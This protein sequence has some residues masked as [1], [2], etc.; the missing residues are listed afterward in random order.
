V[1]TALDGPTIRASESD[2]GVAPRSLLR[3][4]RGGVSS[5]ERWASLRAAMLTKTM[6]PSRPRGVRDEREQRTV[7]AGAIARMM[8][9]YVVS[10]LLVASALLVMWRYWRREFATISFRDAR[11]LREFASTPINALKPGLVKLVGVTK[12]EQGVMSY[13][14]R[15]PCVIHRRVVTTVS[16]YKQVGKTTYAETF[17]TREWT[18]IPFQLDDGT[19]TI[20]VDPRVAGTRVDYET[21]NADED[22]D[23]QE[24]YI[25]LGDRV[26]VIGEI[27]M[28]PNNEGYRAA[29]HGIDASLYARFKGPVLVSWR[30]DAEFVPKVTPPWPA[31]VLALVGAAGMAMAAWDGLI[32]MVLALSVTS[33][34]MGI[35]AMASVA[36]FAR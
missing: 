19:G 28:L 3:R 2:I 11:L 34:I 31:M 29:G 6:H 25:R 20:W 24:Q 22:S 13:F 32:E 33:L 15:Q 17:T 9:W 26:T 4:D 21:G 5:L 12:A 10:P 1:R 23:V 30:S 36:R 7:F 27:E 14:E 16:G 8:V 18:T 35:I